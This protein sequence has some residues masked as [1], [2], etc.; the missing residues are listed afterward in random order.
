MTTQTRYQTFEEFYPY[1]L[2]EHSNRTCRR[3]HF[4]GSSLG[5]LIAAYAV[6]TQS[7]WLI[8]VAFIQGYAFAWVGHFF[9]EHN[10]PATFQYPWM[11][12][13]GDWKMWW[14]TLTGKIAF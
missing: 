11:S 4:I 3:L 5:L 6:V 12:Y 9:F 13:M 7:W 2:Q 1:Y 8:A 10:K 14:Q